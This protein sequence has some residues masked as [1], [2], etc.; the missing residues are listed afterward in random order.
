MNIIYIY[1]FIYYLDE[2][3]VFAKLHALGMAKSELRMAVVGCARRY[4]LR[5]TLY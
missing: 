5:Y 2:G 4:G 1:L 3:R